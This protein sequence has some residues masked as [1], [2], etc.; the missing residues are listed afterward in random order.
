M[1][2]TIVGVCGYTSTGSS[3]FSDLLREYD[4]VQVLDTIEFLFAYFPDGLEDLEYHINSYH[5]YASSA[6]AIY[7]FRKLMNWPYIYPVDKDGI[8]KATDEFLDKLIQFSWKGRGGGLDLHVLSAKK[9]FLRRSITKL[10]RLL[11]FYKI[12]KICLNPFLYRIE[13][14]VVPENFDAASRKFI[15]D[16]LDALGQD[17]HQVTVLNQPFEGCDPVKS[18]K[19]FENPKAIVANRDPRD[20]YLFAKNFLR[21]RGDGYQIPCDTVDDYIKYYRLVHRLPPYLQERN[22]I[23]FINFEEIV[24][25]YE[26]TVKKVAAFAGVTQHIYKGKYFKPAHSRNNTQLF[27]KY[28][29][30]ESD[31]KKIEQELPEYIFHFENYPDIEPEGGMFFGSQSKKVR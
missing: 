10:A 28:I 13:L 17:G 21:P 4:G 20:H 1:N 8:K 31:I 5:K 2:R 16:I 11:R 30:F 6:T 18:F 26:N 23:L 22:D 7:R 3:A 14:S 27:K 25:D 12:L 15:S 19:F 9:L 29:G 24:Y